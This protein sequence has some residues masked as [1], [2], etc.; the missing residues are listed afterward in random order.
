MLGKQKKTGAP[1]EWD[2]LLAEAEVL[3]EMERCK[4]CMQPRY[5]CQ[6]DDP[7]I[8]FDIRVETCNATQARDKA[9]KSRNKGKKDA[10]VGVLLGTEPYSYSQTPLEMF[11]NSFYET[12]GVERA[13]KVELRPVRPRDKPL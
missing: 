13:K 3:V 5:I 1:S 9:E 10:P 4:Q 6:S 2:L 8:A 12:Q 11:R 7:D